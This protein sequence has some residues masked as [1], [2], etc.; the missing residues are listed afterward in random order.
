MPSFTLIY[1]RLYSTMKFICLG[2]FVWTLG[3]ECR[4]S[5]C[6]RELRDLLKSATVVALQ[7]FKLSSVQLGQSCTHLAVTTVIIC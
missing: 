7:E 6:T 1:K 5:H 4:F 2:L 3:S